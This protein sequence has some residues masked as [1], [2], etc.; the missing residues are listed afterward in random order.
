M[1]RNGLLPEQLLRKISYLAEQMI[2]DLGFKHLTLTQLAKELSVS[3]ATLEK[4]VSSKEGPA[5]PY[6]KEM[7]SI[8]ME[9]SSHKLNLFVFPGRSFNHP[10]T[11]FFQ[12][13]N[14]Y[15]V[16]RFFH[17]FKQSYS[18]LVISNN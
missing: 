11:P 17:A 2:R 8:P 9:E 15:S 16:N 18:Y 4:H 5:R 7:A 3:H 6:F 12:I 14:R 10:Y 13:E 1:P